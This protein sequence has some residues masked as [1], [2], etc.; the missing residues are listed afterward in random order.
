[1]KVNH[2]S[3]LIAWQKATELTLLVYSISSKLPTSE[4]YGLINQLRRAAVSVPSNI[5]EAFSRAGLKDKK[6]FHIIALG[7]LSE[8]E[9]QLLLCKQLGYLDE[10]GLATLIDLITQTRKLIQSLKF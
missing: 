1:M 7:S 10:T 6:H 8:L 4:R 5:A 3:G 9:S 2:F